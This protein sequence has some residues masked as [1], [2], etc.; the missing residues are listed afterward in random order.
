LHIRSN[1]IYR[2]EASLWGGTLFIFDLKS[3]RTFQGGTIEY[4]VLRL[5]EEEKTVEEIAS[6]M[7]AKFNLT[8]HDASVKE[9]IISFRENQIIA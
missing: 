3:S 6:I 5:I 1:I 2:F 9:L 4:E 8:G 7:G